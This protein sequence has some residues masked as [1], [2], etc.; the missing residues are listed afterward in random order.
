MANKK[1]LLVFC[2]GTGMD[3][4]LSD[5]SNEPYDGGSQQVPTNV[6]RLSRAIA[7][8]RVVGNDTISQITF[9]QSGTGSLAGFD[10]Q[11]I[12]EDKTLRAYI[13]LLSSAHLY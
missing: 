7:P 4:L 13:G 2:D 9:Y 6:T 12:A 11:G 8:L 3:G 10:G 5:P 1:S